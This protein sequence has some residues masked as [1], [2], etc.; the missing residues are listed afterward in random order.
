MKG[1]NIVTFL[2][3]MIHRRKTKAPPGWHEMRDLLG[4]INIQ[5]Q[6]IGNTARYSSKK[7]KSMETKSSDDEFEDIVML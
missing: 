1:T 2:D 3:D 4:T 6:F 7:L 5:P